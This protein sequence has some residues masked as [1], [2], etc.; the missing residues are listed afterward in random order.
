MTASQATAEVFWTA[1]RAL[2]KADRSA[3]LEKILEDS[4]TREDLR[5]ALVIDE[6]KKESSISLDDYIARRSRIR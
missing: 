4:A 5:Y 1:F 3:V 2:K 6:R